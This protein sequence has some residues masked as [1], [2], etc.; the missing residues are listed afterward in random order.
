M[1]NNTLFLF[2]LKPH[3]SVFLIGPPHQVNLL[4]LLMLLIACPMLINVRAQ[5]SGDVEVA[6][7]DG[8]PPAADRRSRPSLG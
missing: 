1:Y 2:F 6:A 4:L 7:A 3:E 5:E 8:F